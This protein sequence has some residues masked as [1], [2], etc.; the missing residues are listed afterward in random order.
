[1]R[2]SKLRW[3]R[4][5][6]VLWRRRP[7]PAVSHSAGRTLNAEPA[8]RGA[9]PSASALR[10]GAAPAPARPPVPTY[11]NDSLARA[12]QYPNT[13]ARANI[14]SN[15]NANDRQNANGNA[16][17]NERPPAND[18]AQPRPP[19]KFTPPTK[20][21]DYD[22][23]VHPPLNHHANTPPPAEHHEA[24]APASHP[25]PAPHESAPAPSRPQN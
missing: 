4:R 12:P 15:A 14:N 20:A 9:Q 3:R 19:V 6:R 21:K 22:Y 11:T 25:A 13:D 8:E 18:V 16:N 10:G 17:A 24:S 1:M 23:D 2:W 7:N 5:A